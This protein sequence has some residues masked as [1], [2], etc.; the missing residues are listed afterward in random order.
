MDMLQKKK[1][2]TE[3]DDEQFRKQLLSYIK[4]MPFI[5]LFDDIR[6]TTKWVVIWTLMFAATGTRV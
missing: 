3:C 4:E 1:K 2:P 5:G 6:S